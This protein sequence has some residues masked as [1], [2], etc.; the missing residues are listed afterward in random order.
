[1]GFSLKKLGRAATSGLKTISKPLTVPVRIAQDV[2]KKGLVKGLKAI[3]SRIHVDAIKAGVDFT[4]DTVRLAVKDDSKV[5]KLAT[6][7]IE[8]SA[9]LQTWTQRRPVQT[10]IGAAAA[11]AAGYG[12]FVAAPAALAGGGGAAAAGGGGAAAAAGGTAGGTSA[13]AS[14][15]IAAAKA[16]AGLAVS[17]G[18]KYARTAVGGGAGAQPSSPPATTNGPVV[19]PDGIESKGATG[20]TLPDFATK[21][22]RLAFPGIV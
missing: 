2:Q 10:M 19:N 15:G 4:A 7:A 17:L 8:G 5:G 13:L 9:K 3:P 6:K 1:M 21:I 11:G 14:A 18:A 22:L 20:G 12:A 16:G